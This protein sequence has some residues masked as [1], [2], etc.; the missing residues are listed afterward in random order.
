M[1]RPM[2]VGLLCSF[3]VGGLL[4]LGSMKKRRSGGEKDVQK[5]RAKRESAA[6]DGRTCAEIEQ[7]VLASGT[8]ES[9]EKVSTPVEPHESEGRTGGHGLPSSSTAHVEAKSD[10]SF[11]DPARGIDVSSDAGYSPAHVTPRSCGIRCASGSVLE[12]AERDAVLGAPAA[13]QDPSSAPAEVQEAWDDVES[14]FLRS[15]DDEGP[16][17]EEKMHT[18]GLLTPFYPTSDSPIEGSDV[19]EKSLV[20]GSEHGSDSPRTFYDAGE[21]V[22]EKNTARL[23]VLQNHEIAAVQSRKGALSLEALQ[24][25]WDKLNVKGDEEVEETVSLSSYLTT[26]TPKGAAPLSTEQFEAMFGE[27]CRQEA[28]R[29][30]GGRVQSGGASKLSHDLRLDDVAAPSSVRPVEKKAVHSGVDPRDV[31]AND[32]VA[33]RLDS[34]VAVGLSA[35]PSENGDMT[36]AAFDLGMADR[37]LLSSDSSV[38]EMANE[39]QAVFDE[40]LGKEKESE[41]NDWASEWKARAV[42]EERDADADS[43]VDVEG[44][45]AEGLE[46]ALPNIGLSKSDEAALCEALKHAPLVSRDSVLGEEVFSFPKGQSAFLFSKD[47][48]TLDVKEPTERKALRNEE[49]TETCWFQGAPED[50]PWDFPVD[51]SLDL[52]DMIELMEEV[53]A[54]GDA[55]PPSWQCQ[56]SSAIQVA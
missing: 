39:A 19:F 8:S 29:S 6:V 32:R 25:A 40:F 56:P 9:F 17:G 30:Q 42:A 21:E 38:S 14:M 15:A 4:K 31:E 53:A 51:D 41:R 2:V 12:E 23:E 18:P 28:A 34:R 35:G 50:V 27:G 33:R 26:V 36:T 49:A 55:G 10:S 43:C 3:A 16:F 20:H 7:T 37:R 1:S 47:E 52:D 13:C 54:E 11:C 22:W 24:R 45:L 5:K 48:P 46:I 44:D